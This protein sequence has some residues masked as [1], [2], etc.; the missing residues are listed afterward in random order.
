MALM[1]NPVRG[2]FIARRLLFVQDPNGFLKVL[3]IDN[4][5]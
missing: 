4:G 5:K 3:I 2:T 1:A